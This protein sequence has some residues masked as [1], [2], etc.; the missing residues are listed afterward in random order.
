MSIKND[1]RK[2]VKHFFKSP[3][4]AMI[5]LTVIIPVSVCCCA[6]KNLNKNE[7]TVLPPDSPQTVTETAEIS[8]ITTRSEKASETTV[9]SEVTSAEVTTAVS[10]TVTEETE[11]VTEAASDS[12]QGSAA[13]NSAPSE[14]FVNLSPYMNM[15]ESP[16]RDLY[17]SKLV[18]AGD[19]IAYGF[20][21]YNY[22]SDDRNLAQGSVSMWNLDEF[23]FDNGS[24][25]VDAAIAKQ[26]ELLYML[27]GMNDVN[28]YNPEL[29]AS[30]YSDA[31]S[32][33]SSNSPNTVIVVASV[34]PVGAYSGFTPNSNVRDYNTALKAAIEGFR[35]PNIL[36]FDSYSVLCDANLDLRYE[37]DGGD[38]IHL[39]GHCYDDLL[40]ALSNFLDEHKINERFN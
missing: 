33:I 26:P 13:E 24:G 37:C 17:Q 14:P 7:V 23:Y 19:S 4:F 32:Q 21:A 15:D 5:I 18:V 2:A 12:S 30:Q 10:E 9:T 1:N 27:I 8:E 11:P 20:N 16:N 31:V 35:N 34:S 36:Y 22:I 25:L 6:A 38:G 39:Q 40:K 3:E 29:F 28:M